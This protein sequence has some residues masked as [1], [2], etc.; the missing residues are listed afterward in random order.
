MMNYC[1]L[2]HGLLLSWLMVGANGAL[3]DTSGAKAATSAAESSSLSEL[4]ASEPGQPAFEIWRGAISPRLEV[5]F[6]D[7]IGRREFLSVVWF[8]SARTQIDPALTLAVIE[9]MS[10]F[11]KYEVGAAG[12]RGY[13]QIGSEWM[14]KLGAGDSQKYFHLLTNVR[15]GCVLLKHFLDTS[16]SD[17]SIALVRYLGQSRDRAMQLDDPQSKHFLR[18]VEAART[19]WRPQS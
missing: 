13:M 11:K 14:T 19:S 18:Q 6:P 1:R 7:P 5:R 17:M 3:G 8:E 4:Y 15:T 12:A 16:N 9:V 10:G 2:C